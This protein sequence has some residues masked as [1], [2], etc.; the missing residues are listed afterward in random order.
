MIE[1]YPQPLDTP[2]FNEVIRLCI[3]YIAELNKTG[4]THEDSEHYIFQEAMEAV[5]GPDVWDWIN[6]KED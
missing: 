1:R 3:A 2:K 4:H 5:Y 6:E